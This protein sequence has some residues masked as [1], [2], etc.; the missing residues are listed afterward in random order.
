MRMIS[1]PNGIQAYFVSALDAGNRPIRA[2]FQATSVA[3]GKYNDCRIPTS[4]VG[5][6]IDG[7]PTI[8]G[9]LAKGSASAVA[10]AAAPASTP[11]LVWSVRGRVVMSTLRYKPYRPRT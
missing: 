6:R 5:A 10:F 3:Y 4:R 9:P 7:G 1:P 2:W 8:H 11:M